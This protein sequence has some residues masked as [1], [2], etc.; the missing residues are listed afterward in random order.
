M[1]SFVRESFS[2]VLPGDSPTRAQLELNQVKLKKKYL[3]LAILTVLIVIFDQWTKALITSKFHFGESLSIIGGFFNLTFIKNP[4][5]AFGLLAHADPAF[6]IPFFLIVPLVALFAI[7]YV[8]RKIGDN[9]IR[10]SSALS[11]VIG[12]AIGNLIDR[13]MLGYVIDFLD[14]HWQETYHFPAFNVAD[15]AICVGVGILMLDLIL[16]DHVRKDHA[17]KEKPNAPVAS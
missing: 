9:D 5:A 13:A 12:G 3:I 11:L 14:F 7:G 17:S 2:G 4:G 15:S 1:R 10:I 6:R 16:Q 8:F